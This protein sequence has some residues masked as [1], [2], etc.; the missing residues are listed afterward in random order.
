MLSITVRLACLS[1]A[2]QCYGNSKSCVLPHV[3]DKGTAAYIE[4]CCV[5]LHV[6]VMGTATY[7]VCYVLLYVCMFVVWALLPILYALYCHIFLCHGHCLTFVPLV[8]I[9]YAV[10]CRMFVPWALPY[11]CACC[12]YYVLCISACLYH[13]HFCLYCMLCTVAC[14]YHGHCC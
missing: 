10:Y 2:S 7:I 9:V 14:L 3:F 8:L 6:C 13:W 5:L 11:V 4:C 1:C 12:L